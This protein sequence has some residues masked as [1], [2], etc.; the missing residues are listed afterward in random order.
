MSALLGKHITLGLNTGYFCFVFRGF[1]YKKEYFLFQVSVKV[2]EISLKDSVALS[3]DNF[4]GTSV[5]CLKKGFVSS[6]MS[7]CLI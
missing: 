6:N 1:L 7:K 2:F 3:S 4:Q 5:V